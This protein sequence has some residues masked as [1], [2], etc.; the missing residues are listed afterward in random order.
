M[1]GSQQSVSWLAV[2]SLAAMGCVGAIA[3]CSSPS[4]GAAGGTWYAYD[5]TSL[6]DGSGLPGGQTATSSDAKGSD[7]G[8]NAS[9]VTPA[10]GSVG[11]T[12]GTLPGCT[13]GATQLCYCTASLQGV[14]TCAT[15]GKSWGTCACDAPLPDGGSTGDSGLDPNDTGNQ[16]DFGGYFDQDVDGGSTGPGDTGVSPDSGV[17]SNCN[18]RAKIVYVV[19][20]ENVL[21]SFTPDKKLLKI[22]GTLSC[23]S[24]FGDT[25]FSMSVDRDANAWVLYQSGFGGGGGSIYKVSTLD[26][27]CQPTTFIPGSSGLDLFGMGFAANYPGAQD[28]SV[29]VAGESS[30]SF[31]TAYNKLA[32]IAFPSMKLTVVGTLSTQGGADLTGNGDA[33]LFG[34]FPNTSPPSVR[35][36]DTASAQ[37]GKIYPLPPA[38]FAGTQAWA[39]AN[40]GGT[41]YLFFKG[42]SDP[43][44]NVFALDKGTG[45][46]T[47]IIPSIGYTVTG[48]GVSSCAPTG[49]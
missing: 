21:L 6:G 19:T 18:E 30:G 31:Q 48:A 41:F 15:D 34:F 16:S 12:G 4:T 46:V 27:T 37:T 7:T 28:E 23:S 13:P 25:P 2:T 47:K 49:K 35:Q 32:K 17:N 43:S 42:Y 1:R 40:W 29:Y 38:M 33:E 5:G 20:Q 26:A 10:D 11:D 36:I 22:I 3:S 44:T 8:G 39:F 45:A 14:Q 9:D 24:G